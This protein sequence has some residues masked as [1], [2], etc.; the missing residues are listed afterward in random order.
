M[1]TVSS[2]KRRPYRLKVRAERQR[3]TR[4]RIAAATL[5][6]HEEVGPAQTTVSEIARRAGVQRLTVYNS[7]PDPQDLFAAC[8]SR[9]L[10]LHPPPPPMAG[11]HPWKN[12]QATLASLYAWYR[13]NRRLQE[14]VH[15]DR[16]LLPI[17]DALM[18]HTTDARLNER[19]DALT[20]AL[21]SDRRADRVRPLVRLALGYRT[22]EELT[23]A[24]LDDAA[25]ARLMAQAIGGV[26]R[27]N[28]GRRGTLSEI[29]V[30]RD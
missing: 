21:V 14:K 23:D 15:R 13:Q 8:Q 12:L 29:P 3:A 28:A 6:L 7:F 27:S 5:A 17:L 30:G 18:A 1:N 9:F 26:A 25:A 11:P 16:H 10:E 4:A 20:A 24:G 2:H 19:A 22:W